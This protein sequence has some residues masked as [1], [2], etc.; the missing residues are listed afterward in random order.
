MTARV[1]RLRVVAPDE[2]PIDDARLLERVGSGER[3]ALGEL[4]DRY[5]RAVYLFASRLVRDGSADDV[6]QQVF[7]RV[8]RIAPAFDARAASAK[9]WLFGITVR[10]IREH[11][12]ASRRFAQLLSSVFDAG[13]RASFEPF[14]RNDDLEKAFDRLTPVKREAILLADVEGFTCEEI[15]TMLGVPVGTVHTRLHHARS[16]LRRHL[17]EGE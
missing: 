15:A 10:V 8:A 17:G 4:Y 9:P 7:L 2:A 5:A 1:S 6:V 13:P 14:D 12:R 3:A 16:E 11:T